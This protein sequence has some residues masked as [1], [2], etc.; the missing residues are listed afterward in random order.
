MNQI[1][2]AKTDSEVIC[3]WL[4]DKSLTT[5]VSYRSTVNQ[6]IKFI[7]KPL[8]EVALEDLHLWVR[9]LKLTDKT[10]TMANKILVVKSL[11]SF[12]CRVGY[13]TVNVGSFIKC[14]KVKDNLA[15]RIL[16]ESDCL[17]LIGAA[18]NERDRCLL[19]LMYV[20]GLRV[21]EVCGLTWNDLQPHDDGGKATVFGKGSKTRIVLIPD[22]LW[23][24]LM[25]LPEEGKTVF[26]SRT[27]KPLE[28]TRVHKIMK[29]CA[30]RAGVSQRV[31]SHWLRHSHASHAIEGGCNLRLLQQSLGHSKLETTERYLH[32]S[33]DQGSSQYIGF[34]VK[35]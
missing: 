24:E 6:F 8:V 26:L 20:C 34:G 9:R 30:E 15:E 5:Q 14:P 13:L 23:G 7:N 19:S 21:S 4:S 27:N 28:R 18:R 31:S 33:P 22:F 25:L 32:V 17:G 12:C 2:Q 1:T 29:Q 10:S 16:L 11:F 35:V 3:L